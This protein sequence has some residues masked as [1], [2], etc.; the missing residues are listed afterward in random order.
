MSNAGVTT[1]TDA[2]A[3]ANNGTLSNFALTGT[4]SNWLASSPIVTGSN[5]AVL[6]S[7]SFAVDSNV[8]LY[9]IPTNGTLNIDLN[10]LTN[11]SVSVYDI[12]GRVILNKD[13]SGNE[14]SVD[15]SNFQTG[16]YLFKIKSSEGE[17]NKKVVKK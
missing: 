5:C 17:I 7:S 2:S 11:V 3:N 13:L 10:N 16:I 12:N 8:N 14:N 6:S 9:P 15:L 1:L 4:A